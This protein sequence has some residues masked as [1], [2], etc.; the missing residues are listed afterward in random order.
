MNKKTAIAQDLIF[1]GVYNTFAEDTKAKKK[2]FKGY[3][4]VMVN[5]ESGYSLYVE[6]QY[7]I[8]QEIKDLKNRVSR[9]EQRAIDLVNKYETD[10]KIMLEKNQ[11]DKNRILELQSGDKK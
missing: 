1:S 10:R 7:F 8:D 5:H 4:N 3:R 6:K 9:Y 2:D 11:N